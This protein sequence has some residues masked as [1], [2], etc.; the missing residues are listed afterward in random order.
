MFQLYSHGCNLRICS[1]TRNC[2]PPA[3]IDHVV[4]SNSTLEINQ[5][6]LSLH[7]QML[8]LAVD[9]GDVAKSFY[10]FL[11]LR[12]DAESIRKS[13]CAKTW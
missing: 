11:E 6:C 13:S 10:M 7:D 8:C 5:S 1:N 2:T 3:A 4:T 12:D 9:V